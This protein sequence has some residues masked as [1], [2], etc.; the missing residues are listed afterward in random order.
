MNRISSAFAIL[1]IFAVSCS[2]A[3]VEPETVETRKYYGD[4]VISASAEQP[5]ASTRTSLLK[6]STTVV[7]SKDDA[8]TLVSSDGKKSVFGIVDGVGEVSASFS[9]TVSG[10]APYYAVYPA[11]EDVSISDGV[12]NFKLPQTQKYV[13]NSFGPNTSPALAMSDDPSKGI[14]FSNLCGLLCLNIQ[15]S[16]MSVKKIVLHD[17]AGNCLWGDAKLTIDGFG[18]SGQKMEVTGGNNQLVL[19]MDKNISLLPATPKKFYFVVP[20]GTL[21]HGFA[22]VLYNASGEVFSIIQTQNPAIVIERSRTSNMEPYKITETKTESKDVARRGYYKDIFMDGGIALT[23]RTSLPAATVLLGWEMEYFASMGTSSLVKADTTMQTALINGDSNDSNGVLLYPDGEP[24]FRCIYVNG[25][26]SP[27]HGK[28]LGETG[29][30]RIYDFV[31]NGGGYVGTCAGALIASNGYDSYDNY[32][33]YLNIF[34]GHTYHTGMSETYSDMTVVSDSPLLKYSN[35]GGD[36]LIEHVYHNGG[37]YMSTAT[38]YWVDGTE[39]LLLYANAP[40][41]SNNGRVSCWAYKPD[42]EAGRMVLIGSHPEG[43]TSGEKRDLMG[44]MLRYAVDGNGV[45]DTK[46]SVRNGMKYDFTSRTGQHAGIGDRQYHHFLLDIPGGAK[47]L[48]INLESTST[49]SDLYLSLNKGKFAYFT[50][51]DY[52]LT[53]AGA[54]KSLN[55]KALEPGEWY[56]SVY[57]PTEVISTLTKYASGASYYQYTGNTEALNGVPYSLTVSWE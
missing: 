11:S 39:K 33:Y 14:H 50:E 46:V 43:E 1:S 13:A 2:Q 51:S 44:A 5:S 12:M 55:I 53:Q 29:R 32:Q 47:N 30:K 27:A 54:S 48:K 17:L 8:F 20:Q 26:K 24:R 36:K 45:I 21:D 56:I 4:D 52:V 7:W 19:E 6:D 25:G 18:T 23:S 16:S 28:S 3:E 37:C 9:G 49:K 42:E 34:P 22:A 41:S 40:V 10:T 31:Y 38:K 57:C 35:F 15:A